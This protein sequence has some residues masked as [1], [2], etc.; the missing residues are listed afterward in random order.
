MGIALEGWWLSKLVGF[1]PSVTLWLWLIT[2]IQAL[3][4]ANHGEAFRDIRLATCGVIFLGTPHQGASI[5]KYAEW[6]ARAT[7]HDTTLVNTLNRNSPILDGLARDFEQTYGEAD[8]VCFYENKDHRLGIRVRFSTA[9]H[10]EISLKTYLNQLVDYLSAS[11]PSK[12][13]MYLATDHSGLNKYHG[14]EDGNFLL[15]QSELRRMV[16]EAPKTVE[17]QY[18]CKVLIFLFK[19]KYV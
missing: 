8:I 6:L 14:P 1:W 4:I 15:V 16:K 13:R 9:V 11:L 3:V 7:D 12:R 17:Q 2:S 18:S 19:S 5:A 10:H